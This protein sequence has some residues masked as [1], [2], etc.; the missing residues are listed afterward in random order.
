MTQ[1]KP[2]ITKSPFHAGLLAARANLVPGIFIWSVMLAV[3]LAYYNH[4]ATRS[5]LETVAEWKGQFGFGFSFFA[6]GLAGGVLPELLK[7]VLLQ[8]AKLRRENVSNMLFGF[9]FWGMLGCSV[10]ALYRMQAIWFGSEA[11][12]LVLVKKVLVDQFIFTPLWGTAAIVWA[13]EWRRLG[14][15]LEAL[16]GIFTF[17]F[18]RVR[19]FPSLLAGWGVW[20]PGVSIIYSLPTLLQV[21]LFV[22][23][24]SF[25]SLIVT[26]IAASHDEGDAA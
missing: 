26:F 20:I 18:Y 25:W 24:T 10:D 14:F 1:S 6:T 12:P 17:K 9:P 7:V 19:V 8:G 4:A 21:P 3:V 2:N 5:I 22:L 16:R 11:S 23:A 13:Y 15:R